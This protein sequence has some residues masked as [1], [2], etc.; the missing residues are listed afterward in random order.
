M[1][2]CRKCIN[3]EVLEYQDEELELFCHQ[4]TF[5]IDDETEQSL[6]CQC[7]EEVID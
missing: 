5:T 7:Y 4:G 1:R 6:E 3:C 2:Y